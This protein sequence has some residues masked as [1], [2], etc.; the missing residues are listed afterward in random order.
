MFH[1]NLAHAD[2]RRLIEFEILNTSDSQPSVTSVVKYSLG[3]NK[4]QYTS[5]DKKA[6]TFD[7]FC[8]IQGERGRTW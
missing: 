8:F 1:L 3:V 5:Q 2:P 6:E 7:K 4:E